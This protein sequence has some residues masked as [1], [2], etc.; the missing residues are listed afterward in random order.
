MNRASGSSQPSSLPRPSNVTRPSN[1]NLRSLNMNRPSSAVRSSSATRA[2]T[3]KRSTQE[4]RYTFGRPSAGGLRRYGSDSYLN[5]PSRFTLSTPKGRS[6]GIRQSNIP[7][8]SSRKA[9]HGNVLK[10]QEILQ[11]NAEFYANLNLKNNCL[12]SMTTNQFYMIINYFAR[13]ICG[14]DLDTFIQNGD[15]LLAILNFMNQLEYPYTINKS[16][17]KTPNAPHTFDQIVM[18]LLWL[19][20]AT[21]VSHYASDDAFIDKFLHNQ[22]ECLPNEEFTAMFS[23]AAQEGYLLWNN[24]SDE[25]A[26]FIDRLTDNLV[27]AKLNH[28]VQSVDELNALTDRLKAKS[29]ELVD[30]PVQLDNLHQF[31]QLESKYVEYETKEHD[32]MTQLKQKRDRLAAVKVNWSDKRSKVERSLVQMNELADHIRNQRYNL[33]QYKKLSDDMSSLNAAAN[34]I[35]AEL[36]LIRDE[37][38]NQQIIRA[39]LLKKVSEAIAAINERA[40]QIVK[41]INNARLK[42]GDQDLGKLHLSAN[43]TIQQVQALDQILSHILSAVRIQKHKVQIELDQANGKL[44]VLKA[45]SDTLAND[46]KSAEKAYKGVIFDQGL[47]EKKSMMTKKKHDNCSRRLAKDVEGSATELSNLNADI[48]AAKQKV[49][50]MELENVQLLNDGEAQAMKIIAEK[51]KLMKEM[52]EFERQLDQQLAGMDYPF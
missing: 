26:N 20:E 35:R 43:P 23:K 49:K 15:P 25:H 37:E 6:P 17:L 36:K 51:E 38:S 3:T 42:V 22:D 16:M 44:K 24:E 48:H 32:L 33:D 1:L 31:E 45:E 39:R 46:F 11:R 34:T 18:M 14:K 4:S 47:Q 21:N 10:L 19:G 9:K 7:P 30:H 5:T 2:S 13:L 28:K 52:D 8:D 27:G 12:K 41:I 29:K 40:I 50:Q